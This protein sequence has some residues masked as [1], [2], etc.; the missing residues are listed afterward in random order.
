MHITL[1]KGKS[2]V[3]LS[4]SESETGLAIPQSASVK[5][6]GVLF[7]FKFKCFYLSHTIN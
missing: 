6:L 4:L 1:F 3:Y 2:T 5:N 7:K